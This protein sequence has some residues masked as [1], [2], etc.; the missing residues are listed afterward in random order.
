MERITISLDKGLA[1]Q[2]DTFINEFGYSNR[3]EALRD[4]IR[5]RLEQ[6][7]LQRWD[8]GYCV[9]ALSYVY[10]HHELELARRV[11]SLH[12]DHHDLTLSSVHIHLDHDNCLEVA[13]VRGP[14]AQVRA[15][16][17]TVFA[18]RGVRHGRLHLI[19]VEMREE[20]HGQSPH[21]HIHSNPI[22]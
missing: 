2:F 4:L 12:H 8:E 13:L 6:E 3:S 1:R 9:A 5:E 16:A 10:N 20:R 15:F 22:T 21:A 7:R 19:P 14:T 17:N 18:E 11:T